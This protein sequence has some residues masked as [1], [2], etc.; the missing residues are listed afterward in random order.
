MEL[1]RLKG[2]IEQARKVRE[3]YLRKTDAAES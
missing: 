2:Y 3:K 1:R